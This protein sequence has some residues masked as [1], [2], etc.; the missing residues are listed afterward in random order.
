[1]PPFHALRPT[2][3]NQSHVPRRALHFVSQTVGEPSI[4]TVI[5]KD[6][7]ATIT[8][9]DDVVNRTGKLETRR[10]GHHEGPTN[11]GEHLNARRYTPWKTENQV[12]DPSEARVP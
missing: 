3:E 6:G 2:T 9:R 8:A 10:S 4:V 7:S 5:V 1:M 12:A 11:E